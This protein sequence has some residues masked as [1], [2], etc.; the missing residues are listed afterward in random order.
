MSPPVVSFCPFKHGETARPRSDWH[1]L[2]SWPW[3]RHF[4]QEEGV[5]QQLKGSGQEIKGTVKGAVGTV[6]GNRRLEAEG[7]LEKNVGRARQSVGRGMEQGAGAAHEAKGTLKREAGRAV[8]NPRLA[9]EGEDERAAG[10]A[11]RKL[12]EK[13]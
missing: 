12:N 1:V 13:V 5:K 2:C 9:S 3:G 10:R 11:R 4:R 7:D 6:T 8:G